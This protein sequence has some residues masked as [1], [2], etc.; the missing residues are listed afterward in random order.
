MPDILV[1]KIAFFRIWN[2]IHNLTSLKKRILFSQ[3]QNIPTLKIP[4]HLHPE[5]AVVTVEVREGEIEV[6]FAEV[7]VVHLAGA[8]EVSLLLRS[9]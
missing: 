5:V 7:E 6:D 8:A 9:F 2:K 3:P 1:T 4:W